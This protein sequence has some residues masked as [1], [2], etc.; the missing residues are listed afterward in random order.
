MYCMRQYINTLIFKLGMYVRIHVYTLYDGLLL[1][2]GSI[3]G[4]NCTL[5]L[6][7]HTLLTANV[8]YKICKHPALIVT[9]RHNLQ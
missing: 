8:Q 7:L 6:I 1:V 4:E 5:F 3:I 9:I 2:N